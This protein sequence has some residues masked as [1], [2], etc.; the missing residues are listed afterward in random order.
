M[1]ATP[2]TPGDG[3]GKAPGKL[4]G[5][6]G[7]ALGTLRTRFVKAAAAALATAMLS[8]EATIAEQK[9]RNLAVTEEQPSSDE[10]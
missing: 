10:T 3:S 6:S 7:N 4:R 1:H 5:S 9:H 8:K 2:G